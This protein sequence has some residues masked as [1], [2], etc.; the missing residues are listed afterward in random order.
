MSLDAG[1]IDYSP[2]LIIDLIK[3][4]SFILKTMQFDPPLSL[5]QKS[6]GTLKEEQFKRTR[7]GNL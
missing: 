2:D 7:R 4:N 5:V 6:I 3:K 1:K